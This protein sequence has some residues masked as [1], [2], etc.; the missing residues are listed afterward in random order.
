MDKPLLGATVTAGDF[1]VSGRTFRGS[2]RISSLAKF[3][4]R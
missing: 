4:F 2:E 1:H 3:G